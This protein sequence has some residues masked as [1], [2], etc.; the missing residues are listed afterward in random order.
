MSSQEKIKFVSAAAVFGA[1]WGACEMFLGSYL[2]MLNI[3]FRGAFMAGIASVILAGGRAFANFRG[4]TFSMALSA[5]A[6]KLLGFGSFKLGPVAG[7]LIEGALAE[8]MFSLFGLRCWC[9]FLTSILLC[10]EAVPHF[11]VTSW[12][13]YGGGIFEAYMKVLSRIASIFRLPE[14][15]YISII[16]LWLGA[17]ILIGAFFGRLSVISVRRLKHDI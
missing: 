11:F 5:A 13:M 15:F 12:I 4:I 3:P 17:H 10:M 6:L 1:V 9:V 8:F 14:N 7:I 2:H 16:T